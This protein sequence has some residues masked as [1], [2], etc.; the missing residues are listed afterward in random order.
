MATGAPLPVREYASAAEMRQHAAEVRARLLGSARPMALLPKK[1]TARKSWSKPQVEQQGFIPPKPVRPEDFQ[2]PCALPMHRL[3]DVVCDVTEFP[4]VHIRGQRRLSSLVKAR[5]I[6][7]WLCK[8]F[9]AASHGQ[10][11]RMVGG[12][13][14]STSMNGVRRVE[15]V[16]KSLKIEV[17]TCPIVMTKRLWAAEWPKVS[18]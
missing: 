7:F 10:V 9:T 4:A 1:P 5:H 2:H 17:E 15:A 14:H 18:R 3:L 6:L 8:H 12:R 16:M 13:D 11:G